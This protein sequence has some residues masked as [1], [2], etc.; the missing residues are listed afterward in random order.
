MA[1][2]LLSCLVCQFGVTGV[3][4]SPGFPW[5]FIVLNKNFLHSLSTISFVIDE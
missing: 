4:P 1:P 3:I 5:V 2:G